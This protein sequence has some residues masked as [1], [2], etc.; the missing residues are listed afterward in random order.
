M[1]K[2]INK[3]QKTLVFEDL[4]D[5]CYHQHKFLRGRVNRISGSGHTIKETEMTEETMNQVVE[6]VEDTTNEGTYYL[7]GEWR[8]YKIIDAKKNYDVDCFASETDAKYY[9]L[10]LS[11]KKEL[12]KGW[13]YI[14]EMMMQSH[15]FKM[16]EDYNK[17]LPM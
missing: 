15:N 5:A 13:R 1:E 12:S 14:K 2:S 3:S 7:D 11:E 17:L 4:M 16:Y 6:W 9:T 8:G 10:T